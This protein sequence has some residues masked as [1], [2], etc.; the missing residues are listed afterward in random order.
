[1]SAGRILVVD[2]EPEIRRLLKEI[3]EDEKYSVTT[4]ENAAAARAAFSAGRPD[5]VLLDIWMPDTDGITLLKEWLHDGAEELPVVMISGHGTVETAV[6]AIRL[7]AYDFIEK[8]LSTAKL[9]I[10]IEHALQNARLKRENLRLRDSAAP[11]PTLTGKSPAMQALRADIERIAAHDTWVLVSGEPGSGKQL[12][13][14]TL[15]ELSARA[16]SRFVEIGLA[17]VPAQNVA[18]Q[19][20]GAEQNGELHIGSFEQAGGGTLYLSEIGDLDPD[21]QARLAR[22][23]EEKHFL[24]VGGRQPVRLDVRVIAATSHDLA[25]AVAEGRFREDL[26]Y[27]LNVVPLKVP[28]LREHREDVPDLINYYVNWMVEHEHLPY[29]RFSTGALN[30][31]RNYGWPGNVREL[32]NLVQRLLILQHGAEIGQDEVAQSLNSRPVA[33][34]GGALPESW[35]TLPLREA[36]DRFEKAYLE[37]H[38]R[39]THGNVGE[40]AHIVEMERTHLYRKLKGLGI[41]PKR[42]KRD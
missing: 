24:R 15:H 3:L 37:H 5:L 21:M 23:L 8:P 1:M 35:F 31:L 14:R 4:A 2:D 36:R 42:A 26:Y 33:A 6:E 10:T 7:G 16:A 41:E 40:L 9:L 25:Q 34:A 20:F 13:A 38:L 30:L 32:K 29:R 12:A 18:V 39:A 28:A 27:R 11:A 22:A 19:L 17:A